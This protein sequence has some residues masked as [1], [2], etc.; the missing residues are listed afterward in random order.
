[1]RQSGVE[2]LR[3]YGIEGV[4]GVLPVSTST[5][6]SAKFLLADV[7]KLGMYFIVTGTGPDVLIGLEVSQD[8][9]NFAAETGYADVVNILDGVG[10]SKT[11][12]DAAIP[13]ARW[14]RFSF[15]GQNANPADAAVTGLI[16]LIR[17]LR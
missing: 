12:Y 1:M 16:N 10:T 6:Y 8:G 9:T 3:G 15:T 7:V 4:E 17:D 14:G 11:I 5:V 2:I 13:A